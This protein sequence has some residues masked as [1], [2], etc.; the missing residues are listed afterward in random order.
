MQP[1]QA[2]DQ[3]DEDAR[4][5]EDPN[6]DPMEDMVRILKAMPLDKRKKILQEFKTPEEIEK[7]HEILRIIRLG[8]SDTELLQE[9]RNQLQQQGTMP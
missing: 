2:K 5:S 1:K 3:L 9:T 7:L 4:R 6:D 8:G